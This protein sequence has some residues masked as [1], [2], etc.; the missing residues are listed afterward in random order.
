MTSSMAPR[1][2]QPVILLGVPY[3]ATEESTFII[4]DLSLPVANVVDYLL[5]LGIW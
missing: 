1:Y 5:L 4:A 2:E 3:R